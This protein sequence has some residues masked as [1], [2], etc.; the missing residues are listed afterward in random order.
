MQ[1][2]DR[3]PPAEVF[4]AMVT[5]APPRFMSAPS[6][7]YSLGGEAAELCYRAGLTLD[8][9][10]RVVV[11]AMLGMRADGKFA[12]REVG[13]CEPR[14]NGKGGIL[15]ARELAGVVLL[16][17]KLLI[18]S[19]H[20]YATAL[21]AFYRMCMLVEEAGIA[22]QRVRNAHGEQGI[23][24][25]NGA[26]LR[27][28]TRTRGGGR[29][30]SC[31]FL[32]LDEAMFLAEF[33]FGAL[34]PTM[35]AMPNP[36]VAYMGSAVDQEVHENGVVFARVRD[37]GVAGKDPSLAWFEWGLPYDHPDEVPASVLSDPDAWAAANAAF[38]DRISEESVAAEFR[39]LA[40]RTFAVER[41]GVGDWPATDGAS[42]S[43][44]APEEWDMLED[45]KSRL[46]DPV[47]LAFD[48][49]PDR[50]WSS[51]SAAGM[52]SDGLSHLE[53]VDRRVG[54][55]WVVDRVVELRD[56]HGPVAVLCDG[57]SP[58]AALVHQ[59]EQRGVEVRTIT[60]E[61]HAKAC[62][63]LVDQVKEGRARHLGQG[64]LAAAVRG[65]A[66]RTLGEAWAWSRRN[67]RVD[68]S[69]LVSVTLA[70][71]GSATERKPVYRTAGFS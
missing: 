28:R 23:D 9:H 6:C 15:E 63:L 50:K 27:Y 30:F 51:I 52:N 71:W 34:L 54:T 67:S 47:C 45:L 69:P 17:E 16:G 44:I 41:C 31:D 49:T 18:H 70:L 36:Q 40:A 29:G 2:R 13:V 53:L 20:E 60:A 22:V 66:K 56:A 4:A 14:Q 57:R 7:A 12:A 25:A 24:F 32:A 46:L 37:R 55:W 58:A 48:V 42:T 1:L 5:M 38:G 64:E 43:D 68:I 33:A 59:L 26:R 8:S 3:G 62:G 11:D 35:S 39:A 61:E 21:E 19:A 10:Q 65:A